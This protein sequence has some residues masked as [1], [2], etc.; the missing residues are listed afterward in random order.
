ML[1]EQLAGKLRQEMAEQR[2]SEQQA[3]DDFTDH[4]RLTETPEHGV[5]QTRGT[6]HDDELQQRGEQQILG[7]MNR[8]VHGF[9]LAQ[10]AAARWDVTLRAARVFARSATEVW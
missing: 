9:P 4:A 1:T 5:H 3:G 10:R 2:R 7:L 8:H 6:H